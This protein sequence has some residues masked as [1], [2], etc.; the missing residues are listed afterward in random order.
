MFYGTWTYRAIVREKIFPASRPGVK[1]KQRP[2]T[3]ASG[4]EF[5][6]GNA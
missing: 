5:F 3:C 2:E 4:L 6:S 1:Q